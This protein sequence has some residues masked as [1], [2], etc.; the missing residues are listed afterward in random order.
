MTP[1]LLR[2]FTHIKNGSIAGRT[3]DSH[4]DIP[5]FA[6][7]TAISENMIMKEQEIIAVATA[8]AYVFFLNKI[9]II[10]SIPLTMGI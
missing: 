7:K 1:I 9:P 10:N 2:K 4:R 5:F 6:D 3:L 8:A